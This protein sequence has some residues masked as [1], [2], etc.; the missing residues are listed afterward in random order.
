MNEERRPL[1]RRGSTRLVHFQLL[2]EMHGGS[3]CASQVVTREEMWV[4]KAELDV[5]LR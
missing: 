3:R 4:R 1:I 5:S 2:A